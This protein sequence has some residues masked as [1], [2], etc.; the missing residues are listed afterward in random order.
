VT[1]LPHSGDPRGFPAP[2][3]SPVIELRPRFAA[4]AR[5]LLDVSLAAFLA[6]LWV[7][8]EV[9]LW[10]QL[11][12]LDASALAEPLTAFVRKPFANADLVAKARDLLD[13]ARVASAASAGP[14]RSHPCP[15]ADRSNGRSSRFSGG[16]RCHESRAQCVRSRC[17]DA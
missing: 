7:S 11:A 14:A 12:Y 4:S 1:A 15:R 5:V 9:T 2:D 10:L 16:Q 3:G 17:D 8:G 13:R 6:A